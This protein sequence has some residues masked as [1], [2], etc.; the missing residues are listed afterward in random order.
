VAIRFE[1][2][3]GSAFVVHALR[4]DGSAL[5][6]GAEVTDEA[7]AVV[8]YVGQASKA[9]VRLSDGGARPLK[10]R[11]TAD[12]VACSLEWKAGVAKP[13]ELARGEGTCRAQ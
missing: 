8:G 12:G 2:S 6:F 11:L 9:L 1:T 4:D 5:P 13:G 7:G 10:V 3:T